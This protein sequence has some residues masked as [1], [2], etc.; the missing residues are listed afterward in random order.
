MMMRCCNFQ[1]SS[2]VCSSYNFLLKQDKAS[3]NSVQTWILRSWWCCSKKWLWTWSFHWVQVDIMLSC[4]CWVY[5]G[6]KTTFTYEFIRRFRVSVRL[7]A[8]SIKFFAHINIFSSLN[9]PGNSSLESYFSR[10][11][12]FC[13]LVTDDARVSHQ[14]TITHQWSTHIAVEVHIKTKIYVNWIRKSF[15]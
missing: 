9:F 11:I 14:E 4:C 15:V 7:C 12:H 5:V 2:P 8:Y 10:T 3:Y 13:W 6:M 1:K